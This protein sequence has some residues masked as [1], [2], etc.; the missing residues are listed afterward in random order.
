M[1]SSDNVNM[2]AS[3]GFSKPQAEW[4]LQKTGDNLQRAADYLFSH[5]GEYESQ[6]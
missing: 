1:V 5:P 6:I 4:A 3:M 2:L